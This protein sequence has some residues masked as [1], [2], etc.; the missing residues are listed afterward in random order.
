MKREAAA[1]WTIFWIF[2][3]FALAV[4]L[5]SLF[6]FGKPLVPSRGFFV[7]GFFIS[8]YGL[9]VAAAVVAAYFLALGFWPREKKVFEALLLPLLLAGVIGGRVGFVL[10]NLS[11]YLAQPAEIFFFRQGGLS[12]HGAAVASA[13]MLWFWARSRKISFLALAD[14]LSLL[15]VLGQAI[16]RFGNFFNQEAFGLPTQLPWRIFIEPAFRPIQWQ[17]EGFFHPLFLYEALGNLL[18]FSSLLWFARRPLPTGFVFALYLILYSLLRFFLEFLRLETLSF[19]WL[20]LAQWVSLLLAFLGLG[21][22]MRRGIRSG[23]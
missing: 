7:F 17:N 1:G 18:I 15:L 5:L 19:G 16:G 14:K 21:L 4:G 23:A 13:L 22:I 3:L 9:L 6:Y 2:L 10:T 20:T 12:I 11:Y 8:F